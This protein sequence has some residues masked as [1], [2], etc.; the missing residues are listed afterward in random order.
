MQGQRNIKLNTTGWRS[1]PFTCFQTTVSSFF[2]MVGR[3]I[4]GPTVIDSNESC[5]DSA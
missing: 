1:P 2:V 4:F 3:I 5:K